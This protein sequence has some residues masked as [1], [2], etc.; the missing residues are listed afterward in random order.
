MENKV[1]KQR[2]FHTE[3]PWW[4]ESAIIDAMNENGKCD[5]YFEAVYMPLY[6]VGPNY[7][8]RRYE[9]IKSN[10]STGYFGVATRRPTFGAGVIGPEGEPMPDSISFDREFGD[11][12]ARG[13]RGLMATNCIRLQDSWWRGLCFRPRASLVCRETS[14]TCMGVGRFQRCVAPL[15]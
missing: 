8:K 10:P 14:P 6:M 4:H 11:A 5:T 1:I 9:T 3:H 2:G 12:I 7:R 15:C 13:R